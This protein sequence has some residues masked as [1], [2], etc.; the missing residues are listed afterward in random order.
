[1][2]DPIETLWIEIKAELD[3]AN[4]A[5]DDFVDDA[6]DKLKGLGDTADDTFEGMGDSAKKN[7]SLMGRLFEGVAGGIKKMMGGAA[8]ETD[9]AM[10][11]LG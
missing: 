8:T 7:T 6:E 3:A 5:I 11:L 9:V 2:A 1:M 4:D 10:P